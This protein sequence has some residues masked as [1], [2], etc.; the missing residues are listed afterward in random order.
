MVNEFP[1]RKRN[2][3]KDH[4]YSRSGAYFVTICT[5]NKQNILSNIVGGDV[6]DAPSRVKLS[7]YGQIAN[8]YINKLNDFYDHITVTHYVI[9]PNHI[10]FILFVF[11]NGASRTSPPTQHSMTSRFVS[12]FKRF[13]NKEYGHNIWQ[14]SFHDHIIRD[15]KSYEKIAKYISENPL[16]WKYDCFY[17]EE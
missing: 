11:E 1:K 15:K 2:R 9:M 8:K 16:K 4:D 5:K 14:R 7:Q 12:T 17:T 10:H 13:C 3:L 6:L